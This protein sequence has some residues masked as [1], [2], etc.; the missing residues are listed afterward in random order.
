MYRTVFWTLWEKAR[1]G[2]FERIALKH[3]Y[4]H[5]WNRSPVQVRC[6]RQ[7]AQGWCTG[8]TKRDGMG[9]E[10]E[11]GSGWGTHVHPWLI[12]VNVR[13][14]PLQY[15]KVISLQLKKKKERNKEGCDGS[16][17]QGIPGIA[18]NHPK[19]GESLATA[20]FL[21]PV[22]RNQRL[23]S[24]SGLQK[25]ERRHFCLKAPLCGNLS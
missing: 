24:D 3:V 1:V 8:M 25:C 16:K 2:W 5:M 4:Y 10:G 14:K 11:R 12:H 21:K 20:S 19:L 17:S 7:G 23:I 6:M 18:S 13:Q 9:R 15:C 22:R